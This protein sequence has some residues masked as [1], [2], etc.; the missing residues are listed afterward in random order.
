MW[1]AIVDFD[2]D[3]LGDWR[4]LL[5]CG[6]RQHVRHRPPWI[7]RPWV[8]TPEGRAAMLGHKLWCRRCERGEPPDAP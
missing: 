4:A 7:N 2:R 6:H 5:A 8:T 3:E 1:Q